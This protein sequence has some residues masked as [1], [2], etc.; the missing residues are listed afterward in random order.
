M[1]SAGDGGGAARRDLICVRGGSGFI[2]L[3][4]VRLSAS[5]S[6]VHT[7]VKNMPPLCSKHQMQW[8]EIIFGEKCN[9]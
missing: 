2:G 4:P 1:A 3:W 7:T 5:S 6:T 8:Y 9:T